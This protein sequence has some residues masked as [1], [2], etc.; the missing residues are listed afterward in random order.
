[1]EKFIKNLQCDDLSSSVPSIYLF[2]FGFA[3]SSSLSR[4]SLVVAGGG[5]SQVAAYRLQG[6][7]LLQ[8]TGS[9]YTGFSIAARGLSCLVHGVT[10]HM[11]WGIFLD[12]GSNPC[13]LHWQADS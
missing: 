11:A 13:P 10:C 8:R 7:L 5:Y 3:G 4:L 6:L 2:K 12:Q 1:M 9:R